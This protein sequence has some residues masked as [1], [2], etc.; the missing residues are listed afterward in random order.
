MMAS[1]LRVSYRTLEVC[2]LNAA[3]KVW[4]EARYYLLTS[5]SL[6]SLSKDH[7]FTCVP[8]GDQE[9]LVIKQSELIDPISPLDSRNA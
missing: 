2:D 3:L 9:L 7:L 5:R 6:P 1:A 8:Q 4:L